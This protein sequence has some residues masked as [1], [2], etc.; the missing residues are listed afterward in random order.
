MSEYNEGICGALADT[1]SGSRMEMVLRLSV[2]S[3]VLSSLT[4]AMDGK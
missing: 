4:M 3:L 2:A 1:G